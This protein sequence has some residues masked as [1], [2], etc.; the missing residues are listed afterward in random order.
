[1]ACGHQKPDPPVVLE[2][3]RAP[4]P[5]TRAERRRDGRLPRGS[6]GRAAYDADMLLTVL[7]YRYACRE[8]KDKVIEGQRAA[9]RALRLRDDLV[10][11]RLRRVRYRHSRPPH[12]GPADLARLAHRSD[13]GSSTPR[14]PLPNA[15]PTPAWRPVSAPSEISLHK[16]ELIRGPS[17]PN[18][19]DTAQWSCSDH[20]RSGCA[21]TVMR[22]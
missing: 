3:K 7:I 19:C 21:R 20:P 14:S 4:P 9:V 16:A 22:S 2:W 15:S 8:R 11:H 17:G 10:G 13:A 12:P 5:S 18:A 6:A 1:M